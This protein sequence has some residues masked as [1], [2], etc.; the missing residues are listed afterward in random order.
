MLG[1][2]LFLEY[3]FTCWDLRKLYMQLPEYNYEQF[4]S[5]AERFFVVEGRQREHTFFGGR[6]WDQLTL[7]IYRQTWFAHSARILRVAAGP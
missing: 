5:G 6:H 1:L 2:A 4:A 3:V 7:A